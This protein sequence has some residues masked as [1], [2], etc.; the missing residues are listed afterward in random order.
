MA[1]KRKDVAVIQDCPLKVAACCLGSVS[2]K[3]RTPY[4]L[5]KNAILRRLA[6]ET[7][8]AI[9]TGAWQRFPMRHSS[10]TSVVWPY[11]RSASNSDTTSAGGF[12]D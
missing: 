7:P 4:V 2:E 11:G 6:S 8:A 5:I 3:R 9:C 1:R 10:I 12:G